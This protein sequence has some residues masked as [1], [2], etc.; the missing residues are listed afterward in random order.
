MDKL[1]ALGLA[2]DTLVILSSDNGPILFDGY[3]D[4]AVELAGDHKPAGP[5]QSG[6]YSIYE[7]GTRVP[8]IVRWPGHVRA[9]HVSRALVDHVDLFASLA[10]LVGEGL[11]PDAALD[12]FDMLVPLMGRSE[13]GRDYVV[14]DTKLMVTTGTKV[15]SSGAR[16]TCGSFVAK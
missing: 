13:K 11:P 4:R 8:M 7:G 9:G 5:Y 1:E 3:Q 6:K 12:S 15:A 10:G 16:G 2:D 14:E